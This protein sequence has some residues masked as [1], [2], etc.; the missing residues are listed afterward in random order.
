MGGARVSVRLHQ[1][2]A[3]HS[4]WQLWTACISPSRAALVQPGPCALPH[5]PWPSS[6]CRPARLASLCARSKELAAAIWRPE[7]GVAEVVLQRGRLLT[8]MGFAKGPRLFLF[9]EEAV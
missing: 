8:H 1:T 6:P 4:P 9:I 7:L 2:A 3:M 5:S